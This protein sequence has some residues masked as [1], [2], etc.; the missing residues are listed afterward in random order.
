M[1]PIFIGITVFAFIL[2]RSFPNSVLVADFIQV[3]G[4]TGGTS[5]QALVQKASERLG[6]GYP[7]PIQYF[8]FLDNFITGH[9]GYVTKPLIGSTIQLISI[10]LPNSLQLLIL[11]F[12]LT[13][14]IGIPLGTLIGTRPLSLSD[15]SIRMFSLVGFAMPQFFFGLILMLIF[16]KGVANWPGAIF[17]IF[18]SISFSGTPPSWAYDQNLGAVI[19][20][21]THMIFF[22]ALLHLDIPLAINALMHLIL[23]V[24]T[25]SYALLATVIIYLRA[26]MID[27]SGQEY[28]K[29]AIAKGV[30][31]KRL[32][33]VHIRRNAIIPTVTNIGFFM[34]YVLGALV[35]VEM[36]FGYNGIGWFIAQATIYSQVYGIVYSGIIFGVI[37]MVINFFIDILYVFLDPR[38]RY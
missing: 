29:T 31:M 33:K 3:N 30:P 38:I 7:A 27:A 23:P 24:L 5:S 35:V 25:L 18:G 14:L 1:F 26:G 36:L 15:H 4:T 11:S 22:D 16:G 34:T 37:L 28:V 2:L 21:P 9:W 32:V 12:S 10:L 8:L 20:T 19:S 17:P 13:L 6:L